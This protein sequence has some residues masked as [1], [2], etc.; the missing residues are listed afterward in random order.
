MIVVKIIVKVSVSLL[1]A[2]AQPLQLLQRLQQL[3]M[4]L[5]KLCK[6]RCVKVMIYLLLSMISFNI[7]Y[8]EQVLNQ[9]YYL[10]PRAVDASPR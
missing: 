9:C 2:A 5:N 10:A 6:M 4:D 1:R 7:S 3:R 8:I